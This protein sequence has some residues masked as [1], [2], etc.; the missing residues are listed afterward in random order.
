MI[1]KRMMDYKKLDKFSISVKAF[2]E[3]LSDCFQY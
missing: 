1:S 2:G 3:D